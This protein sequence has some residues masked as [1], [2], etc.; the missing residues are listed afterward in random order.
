M[1]E[2]GLRF[3]PILNETAPVNPVVDCKI[4]PLLAG[5]VPFTEKPL[6]VVP[7]TTGA[8]TMAPPVP[9]ARL[10]VLRQGLGEQGVAPPTVLP[11]S[12]MKLRRPPLSPTKIFPDTLS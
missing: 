3:P 9:T 4:V 11:T 8:S 5:S 7:S 10:T 1:G 2:P 12:W 6:R